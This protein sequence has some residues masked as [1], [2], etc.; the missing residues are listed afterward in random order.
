MNYDKMG[1]LIR[2]LR[3]EKRLAQKQLG[4][5]L[6]L[7]DKTISKWERGLVFPVVEDF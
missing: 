2:N 5:L 6:N 1:V 4:D 3:T 7:S